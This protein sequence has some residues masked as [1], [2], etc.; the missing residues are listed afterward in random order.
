MNTVILAGRMTRDVDYKMNGETTSARFNIAVDRKYKNKD[1]NYDTDFINC[2]AFN[3]TAD[4]ISKYFSKGMRIMIAGRIQTGSYT[5]KDG[6]KVY[7]TDVVVDN[8]EFMESKNASQTV[9][10]NNNDFQNIEDIEEE[11]PFN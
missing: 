5:N 8:A 9:N 6:V 11:L 2:V 1:G 4:F 7:T 3:K 10:T